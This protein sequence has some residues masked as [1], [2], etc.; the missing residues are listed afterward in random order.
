MVCYKQRAGTGIDGQ[1]GIDKIWLS[2]SVRGHSNRTKRSS[3][4]RETAPTPPTAAQALQERELVFVPRSCQV[5]RR[6]RH[7]LR[8]A[9]RT[10]LFIILPLPQRPRNTFT[11]TL[12]LSGSFFDHLNGGWFRNRFALCCDWCSV[13]QR[14]FLPIREEC[15]AFF[16]LPSFSVLCCGQPSRVFRYIC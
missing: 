2:L 5:T 16:S 3:S 11:L 15:C 12:T 9:Y 10:V 8:I 1:D 4:I 14:V 7:F 6:C 13:L